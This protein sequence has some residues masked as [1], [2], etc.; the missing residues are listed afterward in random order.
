MINKDYLYTTVWDDLSTVILERSSLYLYA[1]DPEE[2][3]RYC[4][5]ILQANNSDSMFLELNL[6]EQDQATLI[7]TDESFS[8][9][10]KKAVI[11]FIRRYNPTF[12]YLEATGMSCRLIAPILR[13]AIEENICIKV[14]YSEPKQ[15]R[16]PEFKKVGVNKDLSETV[17]GINPLPGF[18]TLVHSRTEPLFVVMLG[19]E[20]GRFNYLLSN[21][22]PSYS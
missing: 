17:D 15:Y 19:F 11:G 13:Y 21:K 18:A 9:S 3:S 14:V 4:A 10:S 8:L 2:R 7:G 22:Q 20:G 12:V 16:L 1:H 6:D 5:S